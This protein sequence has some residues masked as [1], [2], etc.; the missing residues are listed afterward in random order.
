MK[1]FFILLTFFFVKF[2]FGQH[3]FS[4]NVE[5]AI[6]VGDF[7]KA[8]KFGY[9]SGVKY[10]YQVNNLSSAVT[11]S[12]NSFALKTKDLG[13]G[14]NE[15][16]AY[17]TI[18]P[19]KVGYRHMFNNFWIEPQLGYTYL[20]TFQNANGWAPTYAAGLGYREGRLDLG[21]RYE[22]NVLSGKATSFVGV[23]IGY[24]FTGWR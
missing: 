7:A 2:S 9:G 17:Q 20:H 14:T 1:K 3:E 24:L 16:A 21:I 18:V 23:S 19:M 5:G 6:P 4:L 8:F 22:G 10:G 13:I 15:Y 12:V 11:V